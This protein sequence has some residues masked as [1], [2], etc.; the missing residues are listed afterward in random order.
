MSDDQKAVPD[1][2][3]TQPYDPYDEKAVP[4]DAPS[5]PPSPEVKASVPSDL[6][7]L[8]AEGS[9]DDEGEDEDEEDEPH[10]SD[11]EFVDDGPFRPPSPPPF[12]A[13]ENCLRCDPP[14]FISH[15]LLLQLECICDRF[16]GV[17]QCDQAP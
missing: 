2:D 9:D 15:R 14:R 3:P 16:C 13:S 17:S 4:A 7:D 1:V 6:L 12:D 11:D 5:R 8:E 10:T